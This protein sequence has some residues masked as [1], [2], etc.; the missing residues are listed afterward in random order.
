MAMA[1]DLLDQ[2]QLHAGL[3]QMRGIRVA[4]G[5]HR[6]RFADAA[7][8]QGPHATQHGPHLGAAQYGRQLR[9]LARPNQPQYR[10]MPLQAHREAEF[11][12]R[13]GDFQSARRATL[14]ARQMQKIRAAFILNDIGWAL[15][16]VSGQL[17]DGVEIG[18][19]RCR[20]VA[21]ELQILRHSFT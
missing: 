20:S 4:Q 9:F 8:F 19:L 16:I 2:A 21:F 7:L 5:M 15:V 10:P 18:W 14:G 13:L 11:D 12:A 3:Q 6:G 1:Q 17:L